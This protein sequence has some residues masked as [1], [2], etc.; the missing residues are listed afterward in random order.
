M[1][2]GIRK[3]EGKIEK[4]LNPVY[5]CEFDFQRISFAS[6]KALKEK[7]SHPWIGFKDTSKNIKEY[8]KTII[9]RI[10]MSGQQLF[11][12]SQTPQT[13]GLKRKI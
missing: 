8:Q 11:P 5:I 2:I 4:I 12:S 7:I 9:R 1:E 3:K 10:S 6:P 13:T